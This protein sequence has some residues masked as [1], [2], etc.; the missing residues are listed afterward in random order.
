M[1]ATLTTF[2]RALAPSAVTLRS[3]STVQSAPL[4]TAVRVSAKKGYEADPQVP[5]FT[6]RRE[7]ITGRLAGLGLA[8]GLIGE[9][10]SGRG[11]ISQ[12]HFE[13]G[14]PEG[15]L[16]VGLV[17]LVSV[18]LFGAALPGTPTETFT[19]ANQRD[20][21]KRRDA[22][23]IKEP[24][25]FVAEKEIAIG[26]ISMLGFFGAC[27]LEYIWGGEAPLAHLGL[28]TPGAAPPV[29]L[30]AFILVLFANA[31]GVFSAIGQVDEETL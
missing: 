4:R 6:R 12:L 24:L 30:T 7:R 5:A 11:P 21:R 31:A 3:R 22:D 16:W 1:A 23:P 8:S 26:R 15:L 25:K 9:V 13:T 28:I 19:E 29:W 10:L 27:I 20:V 18:N 2:Q 14:L 17:F